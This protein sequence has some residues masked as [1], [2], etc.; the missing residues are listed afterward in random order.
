ML[1]IEKKLVLR[2]QIIIN[3]KND[4][5]YGMATKIPGMIPS[6]TV[7]YR[8]GYDMNIKRKYKVSKSFHT[9]DNAYIKEDGVTQW[10]IW[11]SWGI[12]FKCELQNR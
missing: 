5:Q 7:I 12:W 9:P 10:I 6:R 1:Q 3:V 2:V 11:N 4:R 8:Y